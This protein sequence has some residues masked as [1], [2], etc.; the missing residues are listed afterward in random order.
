MLLSLINHQLGI[1]PTYFCGK[2]IYFFNKWQKVVLKHLNDVK[3]FIEY[4][5]NINDIHK[6]IKEYNLNKKRKILIVFDDM[7]SARLSTEKLIQ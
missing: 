3:T 2:D 5:N 1:Y 6:N 4:S 7:I